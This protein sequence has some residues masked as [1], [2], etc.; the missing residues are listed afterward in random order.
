MT[1]KGE[2]VMHKNMGT[3]I[4]M[5]GGQLF[6][7]INKLELT[8]KIT[9]EVKTA[10][11]AYLPFLN[12][13][14]VNVITSDDDESLKLNQIR[15]AMSYIIHDQQSMMDQMTFIVTST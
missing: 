2:R 8:E 4:P 10:I 15:V 11:E 7:P 6:E 12:I 3:N 14:N 1:M 5:L 9:V 13:Q